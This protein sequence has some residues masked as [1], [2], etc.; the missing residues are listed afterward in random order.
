[1]GAEAA[2]LTA[3]IVAGAAV[4][5]VPQLMLL[6]V[7]VAAV[8]GV[9]WARPAVAAYLVIGVTPLVAGIDRGRVLPVLRPN[10]AVTLLVGGTLV[11]RAILRLRTG[12]RLGIT[13]RPVERA[14]V[15]LALTASVVPVLA[16]LARGRQLDADD[17]SYALVLWKY[18]VVYAVIRAAVTTQREVA[19]C[20]WISMAAAAAVG[21]IGVLQ[22]LDLF[23][24]RA[25][26]A[27]YYAPFGHVGALAKPRG[28]S[29][30][31]LPAATA[32]LMIFNLAVAWAVWRRT[33][34]H[35]PVLLALAGV[36]A[37]ASV[38][39]GEFSSA[40]GLIVGVVT[41][42]VVLRAVRSLAWVPVA[43]VV[44][45]GSLRPVIQHR[46]AGFQSPSGM[47]VSWTGR[48]RNLNTYF[49]PRIAEDFNYVLGV[50][51]AAR[52][53]VV[54]QATGFVWIESGY[55][56]LLW[57]GGIPLLI[58]FCYFSYVAGRAGWRRARSTTDSSSI[59]AVAVTTGVVVIAVLMLFDPHVTYRGSADAFFALIA[60]SAVGAG[61]RPTSSDD[62]DAW[63]AE[64]PRDGSG[65]RA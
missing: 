56:W 61:R 49:W 24:V 46:L 40:I 8:V 57:G 32:D 53:P 7:A 63:S 9:V 64:R 47:P 20:L 21:V 41:M 4:A 38:A 11:L 27:A 65:Q 62:R 12:H 54:K 14:M 59:A 22:A 3:A 52:V 50:R 29:T 26:L 25:A 44:I 34:R 30:L 35:R 2:C 43:L 28:G 19:R 33:S 16:M 5:V 6:T 1:M 37:F 15:A 55:T 10:E 48:L 60:L 39:A 45:G 17:I 13:I 42:A 18:L 36:F 23:G 31:G 51:P 58:A